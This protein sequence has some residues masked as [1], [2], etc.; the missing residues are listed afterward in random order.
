MR[1]VVL[2][3]SVPDLRQF[4]QSA[5]LINWMTLRVHVLEPPNHLEGLVSRT[6]PAPTDTVAA[7]TKQ[8]CV[9]VLT[10]ATTIHIQA[11]GVEG[12]F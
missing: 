5:C 8:L 3:L 6:M 7:M 9:G 1:T 2:A 12:A 10:R 11:A 4:P